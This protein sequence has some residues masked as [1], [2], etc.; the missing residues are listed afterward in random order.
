MKQTGYC[1]QIPQINPVRDIISNGVNLRMIVFSEVPGFRS[2]AL[3]FEVLSAYCSVLTFLP[4]FSLSFLLSASDR[5]LST[6][7]T[8]GKS[9]RTKVIEIAITKKKMPE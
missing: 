9:S 5:H 2:S 4:F 6:R 3:L 7:G 1:P 8:H